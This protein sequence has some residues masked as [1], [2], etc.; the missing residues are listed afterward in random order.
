M[1]SVSAVFATYYHMRTVLTGT[2]QVCAYEC[3]MHLN[4]LEELIMMEA[5]RQHRIPKDLTSLT[6]LLPWLPEQARW[7]TRPYLCPGVKSPADLQ[8]ADSFGYTYVDWSAR[9]FARIEDVPRD[10]PLVYDNAYSNH[11]DRGIYVLKVDGS[12]I[13]YAGGAWLLEFSSKHPE[14]HILAPR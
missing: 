13:W 11:L 1:L 8:R 3:P 7:R 5:K 12:V 10:Y 9:T 2:T 6:N 4:D 14:Y